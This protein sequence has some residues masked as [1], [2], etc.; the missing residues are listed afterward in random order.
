M[1][2]SA[3]AADWE[4]RQ[5]GEHVDHAFNRLREG[6]ILLLHERVEP[7]SDGSPVNPSVDRA[8]LTTA[9][10]DELTARGL[11]AVTVSELT[12]IGAVRTAWFR[13]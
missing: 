11:S 12:K 1:V 13:R 8:A 6:G 10:L 4:D 5:L 7:G 9:L 3:D 2:W